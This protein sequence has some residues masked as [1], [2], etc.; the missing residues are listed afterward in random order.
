MWI[1]GVMREKTRSNV[2]LSLSQDAFI[3]KTG[4]RNISDSVNWIRVM[5]AFEGE[6]FCMLM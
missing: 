3:I 2:K 1:I 6:T 5:Q 4:L